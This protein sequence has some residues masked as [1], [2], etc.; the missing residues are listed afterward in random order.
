LQR[1][2]AAAGCSG[3]L[4]RLVAAAGDMFTSGSFDT[5]E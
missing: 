5:D 2:V 1:L 3:W 4:Q